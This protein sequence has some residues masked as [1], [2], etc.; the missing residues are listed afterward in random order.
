MTAQ[1]TYLLPDLAMVAACAATA[2]YLTGRAHAETAARRYHARRDAA[3]RRHATHL[4][5]NQNPTNKKE[6]NTK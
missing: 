3:R 1:A 6:R 5:H 4:D 2:A